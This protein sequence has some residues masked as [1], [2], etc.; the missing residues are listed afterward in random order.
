MDGCPLIAE[1]AAR[2]RRAALG[3]PTQGARGACRPARPVAP[4]I[5]NLTRTR[6]FARAL[7]AVDRPERAVRL[8]ACSETIHED[9]G[10]RT[11]PWLAD[12]NEITLDTVRVQLGDAAFAEAWEEGRKLTADEAAT[13]AL[14]SID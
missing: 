10:T 4:P 7:V 12:Y 6:R 11:L 5:G 8:L 9:L 3:E 14:D 1:D 2:D 13:L